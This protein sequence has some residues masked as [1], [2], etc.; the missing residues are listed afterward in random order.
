MEASDILARLDQESTAS[1]RYEVTPRPALHG[2]ID[3]LQPCCS[4]DESLPLNSD[5]A[6][7]NTVHQGVGKTLVRQRFDA[8][9]FQK[10]SSRPSFKGR[11]AAVARENVE[12]VEGRAAKR[13]ADFEATNPTVLEIKETELKI[14]KRKLDDDVK[15]AEWEWEERKYER[16][17]KRREEEFVWKEKE[18]IAAWEW[19]ER[20]NEQAH[21]EQVRALEI[22]LL[23]KKLNESS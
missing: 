20:K 6:Q 21:K 17:Q 18:R 4:T 1:L 2:N 19:Q 9:E 22:Q 16:E 5:M 10:S 23:K 12:L 14:K 11:I 15:V 8:P 3:G 7:V 13:R